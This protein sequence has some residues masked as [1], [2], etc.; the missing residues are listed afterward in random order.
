MRQDIKTR[1]VAE[2]RSGLPQTEGV[3]ATSKGT[4]D[5]PEGY[6]C[7]GVLCEVAVKDGVVS[8]YVCDSEDCPDVEYDG[9][10]STLPAAVMDWAGLDESN[11][12][13][14]FTV[15]EAEELIEKAGVS[16]GWAIPGANGKVSISLADLNDDFKLNFEEIADLIEERL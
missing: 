12:E 2:L 1:W 5:I 11:P 8:K 15:H 6:C 13:I 3:L 16:A 9:E 7:L 10:K 4:D 14:E